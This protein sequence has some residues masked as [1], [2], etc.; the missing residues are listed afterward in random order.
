MEWVNYVIIITLPDNAYAVWNLINHSLFRPIHGLITWLRPD[1]DIRCDPVIRGRYMEIKSA[2]DDETGSTLTDVVDISPSTSSGSQFSEKIG[3][4][5]TTT[6]KAT[7]PD[8]EYSEPPL[9]TSPGPGSIASESLVVCPDDVLQRE[10]GVGKQS[11]PHASPSASVESIGSDPPVRCLYRPDAQSATLPVFFIL[12]ALMAPRQSKI[13]ANVLIAGCFAY[14]L[15]V[16]VKDNAHELPSV[17]RRTA[18]NICSKTAS[19]FRGNSHDNDHKDSVPVTDTN[20][21]PAN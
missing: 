20:S 4:E 9:I 11:V 2:R 17:F 12:F 5:P 19:M 1:T 21:T 13:A 6:T 15:A 16:L 14:P 8:S 18:A 10:M 3:D 7:Y